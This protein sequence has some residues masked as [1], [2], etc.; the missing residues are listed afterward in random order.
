MLRVKAHVHRDLS[1]Q[2]YLGSCQGVAR[3]SFGFFL[4]DPETEPALSR[5]I[6]DACLGGSLSSTC[7]RIS[8]PK[9]CR[10]RCACDFNGAD[11]SWVR[12]LVGSILAAPVAV[13]VAILEVEVEVV[14]GG[15]V[16]VEMMLVSKALQERQEKPSVVSNTFESLIFNSLALLAID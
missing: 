3:V 10:G 11:V 4:G 7:S 2:L 1:F 16:V 14:V 13:S 8:G 5:K 12:N 9:V 6:E 15:V